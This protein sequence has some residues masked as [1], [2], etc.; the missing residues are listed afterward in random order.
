MRA[1]IRE[2]MDKLEEQTVTRTEA[3]QIAGHSRTDTREDLSRQMPKA[4]ES[5][6]EDGKSW[7]A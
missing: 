5:K 3:G 7:I 2:V 1:C 4:D 6:E